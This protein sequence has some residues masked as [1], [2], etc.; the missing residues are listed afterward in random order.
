M[1][2]TIPVRKERPNDN[3]RGFPLKLRN[4]GTRENHARNSR[5]NAGKERTRRRD[6]HTARMIS[7]ITVT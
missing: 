7:F 5:S 3:V 6:E 2:K 1:K 4:N